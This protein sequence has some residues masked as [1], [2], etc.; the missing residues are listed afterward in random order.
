[1]RRLD[2][3]RTLGPRS[4]KRAERRPDRAQLIERTTAATAGLD[5]RVA[6]GLRIYTQLAVEQG[7]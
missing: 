3:E 6:A 7:T 1:M 5:M 2:G 4:R